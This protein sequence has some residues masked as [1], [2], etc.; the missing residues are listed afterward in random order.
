MKLP[1]I[2][3]LSTL[4]GAVA[5][6]PQK[7]LES[8][9]QP[10]W[11]NSPFTAKPE[12][13][14][15][16]AEVNPLDDYALGGVS[17]IAGGYRVT[18]LNRKNPQERIT[19]DSDR[20]SEFK[21]LSVN[22]KP[23]DPLGTVVRLA[24]GTKQGSVTFDEKL[25]TLQ[26]PPAAPQPQQQQNNQGAV[27]GIPGTGNN[28]PQAQGGQ[29]QPRPRVVPPPNAQGNQNANQQQQQRGG[30]QNSQQGGGRDRRERRGR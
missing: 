14:P 3:L 11:T 20:S 25:L 5:D 23:G 24:H 19:V 30:N 16:P 10:L 1:A 9:Y 6:V 7:P 29:R 17:P 18:L 2:F 12:I 22:R 28:N 8:K 15:G 4:A 13:G 21:I 26:A 27:P